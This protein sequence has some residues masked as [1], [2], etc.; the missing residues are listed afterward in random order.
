MINKKNTTAYSFI[1]SYSST[2]S[3]ARLGILKTPHGEVKT[4]AFVTVGTKGAVK[5]LD[6]VDLNSTKTQCVFSNTYHLILSPGDTIIQKF[7]GIHNYAN[8]NKPIITD[9]GGFQVFSLGKMKQ[10]KILDKINAYDDEGVP[11]LI[12]I[13]D[14]GVIFRSHHDGTKIE[15]TPEFSITAQ[16][17]IGAD[18]IV[19][20]D[21]C[22]FYG[23]SEKYTQKSLNRTHDWA[24]RSI[25]ILK[26]LK[27]KQKLYGVIQGGL[28][29]A[30]REKSTNYIASLPFW[31]LA[32][33]GVSVGETKQEMR[34]IALWVTQLLKGDMRPIHMLGVGH[35][36]DII[37]MVRK[38]IDTFDCVVPT[39]LAR[40]GKL[41]CNMPKINK[42]TYIENNKHYIDISEKKYKNDQKPIDILCKCP[43]C[44][45][46]SRSYLHHLFKQKELLYYRL[47]TIHN[48]YFIETFFENIRIAI[49]ND[50]I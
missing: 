7:K 8:I 34:N 24:K 20:F 30:L 49:A 27:S 33:G 19:A 41:Y 3:S 9:S 2:S 38:G 6:A 37:S 46:Y 40:M 17:N 16:Y 1:T 10:N 23:A 50:S 5:S 12:K 35:L 21:E 29:K 25:I 11:S 36:D 44:T 45:L 28:Y 31:G 14:D 47:A 43:V 15:F 39:R 13:T 42:T 4:P 48:L 26:K 18:L 22:V 32:I